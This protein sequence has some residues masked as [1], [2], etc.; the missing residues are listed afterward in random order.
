MASTRCKGHACPTLPTLSCFQH[1]PT[2]REERKWKK[3]VCTTPAVS[4]HWC[5]TCTFK[6]TLN[7]ES[8]FSLIS[9][10]QKRTVHSNNQKRK[11]RTISVSNGFSVQE[12]GPIICSIWEP[13][14][15]SISTP[16][17]LLS[18]IDP[19]WARWQSRDG[20][21]HFWFRRLFCSITACP[22]A[23]IWNTWT[24]PCLA[25][26]RAENSSS[27]EHVNW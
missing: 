18:T 8:L 27:L 6:R 4:T 11:K 2:K 7:A 16:T 3:H 23:T 14:V 9:L 25:C 12:A 22:T 21:G 15:C 5:E 26:S 17:A 19:C 1:F 13:S 10:C 20:Q 24:L